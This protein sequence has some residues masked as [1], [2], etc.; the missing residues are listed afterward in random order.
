M[1]LEKILN[2]RPNTS[3]IILQLLSHTLSQMQKGIFCA[4]LYRELV[5]YGASYP[6]IAVN[7]WL[8]GIYVQENQE[9]A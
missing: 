3:C 4:F 1:V 6:K 5:L 9:F 7:V 2:F 8:Y